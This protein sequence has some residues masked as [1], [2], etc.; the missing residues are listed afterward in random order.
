MTRAHD[1][2][3]A[4]TLDDVLA[5]ARGGAL[6][7]ALEALHRALAAKRAKASPE[8]WAA[9]VRMARAHPLREFLQLDPFTLR[10]YAKPRGYA[11]DGPALDYVYRA[12]D[13]RIASGDPTAVLHDLVVHGQTGRALRFRRDY[14]AAEID[15][16]AAGGAKPL[17]VFAAGCGHLR[18]CDVAKSL[19]AGRVA[20][21]VAYDL[22]RENLETVQR[23]Y[24]HLPARLQTGTVRQLIEGRHGLEEMDFV[25]CSGLLET[26]SAPAAMGLANA[27]FGMLRRG[28]TLVLTQFLDALVEAAYLEVF[29][30]WRM[31]YRTEQEMFGLVRRFVP[32]AVS[33]WSYSE[34]PESTL[35]I[36][37]M[38]RR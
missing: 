37:M 35:G 29:M 33:H 10:C 30:D 8:E 14:I 20:E 27:L 3:D 9:F 26:L 6:P 15:R 38:Q 32:D 12:R 5:A 22:D 19:R 13:I 21:L 16:L 18:E 34:A 24:P 36:L 31:V 25:Y 1:T 17:R 4:A 2:T 7:A 28:G 23:D 11:P